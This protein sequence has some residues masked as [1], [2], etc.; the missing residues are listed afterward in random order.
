MANVLVFLEIEYSLHFQSAHD[1]PFAR[2]PVIGPG[3]CHLPKLLSHGS[4]VNLLSRH[5]FIRTHGNLP[6]QSWTETHPRR[7]GSHDLRA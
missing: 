7:T 3:G 5:H 4:A 6:G 1:R 2:E